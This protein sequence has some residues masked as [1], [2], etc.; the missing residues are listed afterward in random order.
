MGIQLKTILYTPPKFLME[1][2]RSWRHPIGLELTI[3][4]YKEIRHIR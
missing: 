3:P 2:D 1:L 4:P